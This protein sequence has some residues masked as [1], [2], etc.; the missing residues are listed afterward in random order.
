MVRAYQLDVFVKN[1]PVRFIMDVDASLKPKVKID[2]DTA[3]KWRAR[4]EA[5]A[6]CMF[7]E[8]S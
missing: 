2:D 5:I 7:E 4:L 1:K 8:K 6:N 3:C